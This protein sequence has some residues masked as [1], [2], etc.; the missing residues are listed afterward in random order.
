V[1]ACRTS[2]DETPAWIDPD[3]YRIRTADELTTALQTA[4]FDHTQHETGDAATHF[5]HL[6]VARLAD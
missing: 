6:F 1:I 5:T 2:D 4:G 3:I